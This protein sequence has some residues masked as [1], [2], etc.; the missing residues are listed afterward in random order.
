MVIASFLFVALFASPASPCTIFVVDRNGMV[1]AGGNEDHRAEEKYAGHWVRFFP[2][3]EQGELGYV[4]FGYNFS[5]LVDQAALN[6]AGLFYDYNALPAHDGVNREAEPAEVFKIKEMLKTCR[7]VDEALE[8]MALYDFAGMAKAQ[9]VIGDATGASA[10]VERHTVTKRDP[11][12]DYQIGTNFRTS[13]TPK[14]AITCWRYKLCDKTLSKEEP[15]SIESVRGVLENSMPKDRGLVSW[16]TTVF[17]LKAAKIHLFRKGHFSKAVVID[18]KKELK[19][20]QREIDMD[21]LMESA[22]QPYAVE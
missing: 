9:M 18:L 15:V 4:S 10:I 13:T 3:E 19:N 5:P 16:Y 21:E 14:N 22:A 20:G 6:E 17:D 12:T 8:F 1:I 2:A 11:R 7:T